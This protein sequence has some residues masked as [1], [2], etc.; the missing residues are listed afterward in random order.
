MRIYCF[1]DLYQIN[2]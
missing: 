2:R 1:V